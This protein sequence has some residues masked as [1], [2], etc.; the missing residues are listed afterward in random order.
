MSRRGGCGSRSSVVQDLH[1]HGL[2]R[3]VVFGNNF[4]PPNYVLNADDLAL[5][6]TVAGS[7]TRFA[8]T[9]NPNTDDENVVH[10]TAFRH[11]SGTGRGADKYLALDWPVRE[12][13]RPREAQC[14]FWEPSFLRS[15]ASGPVAA[16]HQ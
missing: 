5:F 6:R 9:G 16:W 10:W 11:P 4:G 1:I 12:D 8:A 14:D 3:N 7:W 13:K 2:D 15:I